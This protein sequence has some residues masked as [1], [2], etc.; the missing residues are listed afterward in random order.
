M[1]SPINHLG[2]A[3]CERGIG[4]VASRMDCGGAENDPA[5]VSHATLACKRMGSTTTSSTSVCSAQLGG[6]PFLAH[7]IAD[8]VVALGAR[9]GWPVYNVERRLSTARRGVRSSVETAMSS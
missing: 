2:L 7:L 5:C 9:T 8:H 6:Q 1:A 4:C 3:G